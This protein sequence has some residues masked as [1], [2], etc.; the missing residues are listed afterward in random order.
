MIS[1]DFKTKRN[2]VPVLSRKEI[3]SMAEA[4]MYSYKPSLVT[5]PGV[6]DVE[7]F[8]EN[9]AEL[10]MDY[11]DLTHDGSILGMIV[12]NDCHIPVYDSERNKAKRIPVNEKTI[13]VDN[14]L[15]EDDQRR[16]G[17]FTLAHEAAHWILHRH[18]Y[19]KDKSQISLFDVMDVA[20]QN[21]PLIKCRTVDIES[22]RNKDF[23][24]D[25]EWM[26]WQ[27]DYLASTMLMPKKAFCKVASGKFQ[28]AKIQIG[29]CKLGTDFETDIKAELIACEIAD[30]FDVSLTAAKIRLKGLG[31]IK[32]QKDHQQS[33][34]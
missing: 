5:D 32:D 30:I 21:L 18:L 29:Y 7:L 2:G 4:V 33:L 22:H 6:L 17:R 16:R 24:T 27:A 1:L 9:Y 14:M 15:L 11:K 26:E 20:Q 19:L 12:F 3:E 13:I 10:E 31:F 23:K 25:E 28:A 8:V 34:F